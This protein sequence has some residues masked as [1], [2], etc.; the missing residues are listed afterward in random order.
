[1]TLIRRRWLLFQGSCRGLGPNC[2]QISRAKRKTGNC[3]LLLVAY[4]GFA[5]GLSEYQ[6]MRH[7]EWG[8]W[9]PSK[10]WIPIELPTPLESMALCY[11]KKTY[12]Q[13]SVKPHRIQLLYPKAARTSRRSCV[14]L[15]WFN[16]CKGIPEEA[17]HHPVSKVG[18]FCSKKKRWQGK[19]PKLSRWRFLV[20]VMG[21]T[22][23]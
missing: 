11:P 8:G 6:P 7:F 20:K 21:Y 15:K 3:F 23:V 17:P 2:V 13:N 16:C 12:P 22:W 9:F 14:C 10:K 1:M 4:E 5:S 18:V 19:N